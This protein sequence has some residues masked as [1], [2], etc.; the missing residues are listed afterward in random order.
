MKSTWINKYASLSLLVGPILEP[1][2]FPGTSLAVY[3]VFMLFNLLLFFTQRKEAWYVPRTYF[4]FLIYAF[5][6]PTINAVLHGYVSNLLGSYLTLVLFTANLFLVSL[7]VDLEYLKKYYR[8][9]A[10]I[11]CGI[12]FAQE[13]SFLI[14]GKRFMALIP[15]FDVHYGDTEGFIQEMAMHDRSCSCFLEPSHFAQFIIPYLALEL[16]ILH[17]KNKEIGF[18]PVLITVVLL[19]LRSGVGLLSCATLWAL[20]ILFSKRSIAKKIL[21]IFPLAVII[22]FVMYME[23]AESE[24]GNEVIE[25]VSQLNPN[26]NEFLSSGIVR[27]YRGYWVYGSLD[28]PNK[29]FGVGIGGAK[30][31]IDNSDYSWAFWEGEHY[32][33]NIQT[34]LIGYGILGLILFVTFLFEITK[35]KTFT[36]ILFVAAF[37]AMSLMESFFYTSKMLLCISVPYVLSYQ[38]V[39]QK[40]KIQ[41][42]NI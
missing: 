40:G 25:R 34:L 23:Y 38:I 33:N 4:L 8:I 41:Q 12:F 3:K 39:C 29:L 26:D 13:V 5:T 18:Y 15:F 16:G 31:A 27:V 6:I 20:F 28:Y 7:F 22:A 17:E 37:L 10:I 21:I 42:I 30:D 11:T 24:K 9:L 36:A 1:Y 35:K 19:L 2:N 14:I 32:I